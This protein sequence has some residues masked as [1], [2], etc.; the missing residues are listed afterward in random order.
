MQ[1]RALIVKIFGGEIPEEFP[2]TISP[3]G[4]VPARREGAVNCP[5]GPSSLIP[6][7]KRDKIV[8]PLVLPRHFRDILLARHRFSDA[9]IAVVRDAPENA[10]PEKKGSPNRN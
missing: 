10:V 4:G 3:G 1:T 7:V 5:A 8:P 2:A 6:A 9:A